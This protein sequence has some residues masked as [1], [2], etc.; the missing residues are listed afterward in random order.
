M[1]KCW[2]VGLL[3]AGGGWW[4][5][6]WRGGAWQWDMM[7]LFPNDPHSLGVTQRNVAVLDATGGKRKRV[8]QTRKEEGREK[9]GGRKKK[10]TD[11]GCIRF[12][13]F[14]PYLLDLI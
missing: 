11:T 4:R 14:L 12:F 13:F 9:E 8:K 6:G 3:D 10:S 2:N 1:S 7:D 5:G